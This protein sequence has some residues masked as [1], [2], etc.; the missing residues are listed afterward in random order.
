LKRLKT[1][2]SF[3]VL[4]V[5]IITPAHS[6]ENT[7]NIAIS[8]T[9]TSLVP[10]YSTDANSQNINRLTQC[11]L[12]EMNA[13]MK[14]ECRACESFSERFAANKHVLT[15]KLKNNLT[16]S[17]GTKLLADDIVRSWQLF[18]KDK[19]INSTFMGSFESIENVRVLDDGNVEFTFSSFSLENLSNLAMLKIIKLK[20]GIKKDLDI[21]EVIGCGAYNVNR[22]TPLEIELIPRDLKKAKLIFKVVKDETTLAL[23]LLNQEIDMSVANM[24]PRKINWLLKNSK[25]LKVFKR[26][27]SN[28]LFMGMN[29][30]KEVFSSLEFRKAI[31]LLIPREKLLQ[32]KLK[33][34]AVLSRGMFSEAFV[35]MFENTPIDQYNPKEA[36]AI[37]LKLGYVKNKKGVLEKE[38]KQLSLEWIVSNNKSSIEMAETIK[39]EFSLAGINIELNIMEWSS[40]M[41]SFK[42]GRFDL[43]VSQWIGFS[44]PDMLKFVFYSKNIPPIG[45][46][47][48]HYSNPEFDKLIDAASV[49]RN[50]SKRTLLYKNAHRVVMSD[51][52]YVNLWHP[53]IVWIANRC[54]DNIKLDPIGGFDTFLDVVKKNGD[55]CGK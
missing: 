24:S 36:E 18:A 25:N 49:E 45:G 12:V 48:I 31:S 54:V 22:V 38:G 13:E 41:N 8:S 44:G 23:K 29:Q 14:H 17:D 27:S 35:D 15:F 20:N 2:F 19:T 53:H 3:A 40:F 26:A 32:Y 7:L 28:Y 1:L 46:N 55:N 34:F 50:Q 42:A 30:R 51:R 10:F 47:R 39:N 21:S 16:F 52:P 6:T 33:D 9:P 4:L 5:V 37:F 11:S 43:V